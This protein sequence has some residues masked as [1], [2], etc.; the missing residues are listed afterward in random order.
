[1]KI[2]VVLGPELLTFTNSPNLLLLRVQMLGDLKAGAGR[3]LRDL[4]GQ[5]WHMQLKEGTGS[6]SCGSRSTYLWVWLLLF[7]WWQ[8]EALLDSA[9]TEG[10]QWLNFQANLGNHT[11]FLRAQGGE[12]CECYTSDGADRGMVTPMTVIRFSSI[13]PFGSVH[14]AWPHLHLLLVYSFILKVTNFTH[15]CFHI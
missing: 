5:G 6:V 7:S 8:A 10:L 9:V 1:M 15:S 2:C 4:G 13:Y 14:P 11:R 3:K 12:G